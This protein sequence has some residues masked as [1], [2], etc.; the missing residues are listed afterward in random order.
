MIRRR[1]KILA[2][3]A[4]IAAA[5]MILT[6]CTP[7]ASNN[8]SKIKDDPN[9]AQL[10]YWFWGENEAPGAN[11]WMAARIKEYENLHPG[12]SIALVPQAI[13]T[14]IG[15]F[16]AAA[17]TR[18]GPDMATQ[19]ATMPVLSQAWAGAIAPISDYVSKDEMSTWIGTAENTA[20]GKV[21][22]MPLYLMGVPF[23]YNKKLFNDAGLSAAPTTFDELLSDCAA[24]RKVG[25]TPFGE[26]NKDGYFGTWFFSLFAKQGLDDVGELKNAIIGKS[27]ITSPKFMNYLDQMHQFVNAGCLNDNAS[28]LT[29]NQG[30][31]L[32]GNSEAAMVWAPDGFAIKWAKELGEDVVGV[33]ATPIAGTGKLAPV[34]DT[35]QSSTEFITSWSKHPRAAAQFLSWLHEPENL[36]SWYETTGN[37]PADTKF[38]SAGLKTEIQKTLWGL[39]SSPGA[40]WLENYLPPSID[41][42]GDIGAGQTIV[43]GGSVEEAIAVWKQ[44]VE[45]WRKT[46]PS[47]LKDYTTWAENG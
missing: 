44:A 43:S 15:T 41:T 47:E 28:S 38:D 35:T 32:F 31:E 14:L 6:G 2:V 27:D 26:G 8:D 17:Q 29:L 19:W 46:N 16:T 36:T 25:I 34:Y 33:A 21:W 12:V 18:K 1:S 4:S 22:G 3:A 37:F 5:A 39:V 40:L 23:V 42:D 7:S 45:K 9:N 11:N 13:D 10:T 24:L 30:Y 20:G